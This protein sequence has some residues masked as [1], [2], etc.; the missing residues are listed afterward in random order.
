MTFIINVRNDVDQPQQT[1]AIVFDLEGF[2]SL[3]MATKNIKIKLKINLYKSNETWASVT[4]SSLLQMATP[5][6]FP[7]PGSTKE[8][9]RSASAPVSQYGAPVSQ[10]C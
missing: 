8:R 5:M 1:H 6:S 9:K 7:N 3:K 4:F 2:M 10:A